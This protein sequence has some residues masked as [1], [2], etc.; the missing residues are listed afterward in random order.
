MYIDADTYTS[1]NQAFTFVGSSNFSGQAG[2]L[3]Y[4]QDSGAGL[5]R[6]EADVNGDGAADMQIQLVGVIPLTASDFYL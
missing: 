2:E 5:T 4:A 6:I 1:G 3:R